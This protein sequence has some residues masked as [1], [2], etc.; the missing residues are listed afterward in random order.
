[1]IVEMN[2]GYCGCFPLELWWQFSRPLVF[3]FRVETGAPRGERGN[4][5]VIDLS[6]F[7]V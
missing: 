6:P 7:L 4:W 5:R 2:R 3:Q 1:M